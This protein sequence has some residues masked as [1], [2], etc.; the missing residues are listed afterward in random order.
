M[1]DDTPDIAT[2]ELSDKH[3]GPLDLGSL[4]RLDSKLEEG[5]MRRQMQQYDLDSDLD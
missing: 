5:R 1:S 2:L 4:R 3:S